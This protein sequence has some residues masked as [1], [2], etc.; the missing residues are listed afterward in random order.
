[1]IGYTQGRFDVIHYGHI[2]TLEACR[3]FLKPHA[4][5][6]VG[7]A[8]DEFC[9]QYSGKRPVLNWHE[10]AY[11]LKSLA[12]VD[13]VLPYDCF[14]G[15]IQAYDKFRY[16]I[17]FC[18]DELRGKLESEVIKYQWQTIFMPR[19]PDISSTVIKERL[20]DH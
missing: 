12:I 17:F 9:E 2:L 19:T 6:I 15:Y 8:T 3:G 4:K 16:D 10:R 14:D 11:V 18:T 5:L 7:V 13:V 1:M 20:H